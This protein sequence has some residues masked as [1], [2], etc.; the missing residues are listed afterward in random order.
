MTLAE[1]VVTTSS[2]APLDIYDL[3]YNK[4]KRSDMAICFVYFNSMRSKRMLMNYLYTVE[5]LKNA[6]IK[7]YTLELYFDKPEIRDAIHLKGDS[8]LFHKEKLCH[9]LENY[10]SW[11]YNKLLFLDADVIFENPDWYMTVSKLL[12]KFDVV[13]PFDSCN[14]LDL[15]YKNISISRKSVLLMDTKKPY[16]PAYHPGFAW[17]FRRSWFRKV[18]FYQWA[19]TG[20]GDTYSAAAWLGTPIKGIIEAYKPSYIE[21]CRLSRPSITFCPGAVYHLYHGSRENRKYTDRHK[22][23]D[24]IKDVRFIIRVNKDGVITL[25]DK[26]INAKLLKYFESREDDGL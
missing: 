2:N 23:L 16:N 8:T 3:R 25:S 20:S 14:W 17:A 24:G 7:Y 5:K 9:V 11:W 15:T 22:I 18:G 13:H 12:D 21:Y 19:I 26:N 10:V 4:P 1:T 6:G